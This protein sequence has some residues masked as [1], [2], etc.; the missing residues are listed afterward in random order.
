MTTRTRST[1]WGRRS[2]YSPKPIEK[3]AGFKINHAVAVKVY[4]RRRP[5][6]LCGYLD[7]SQGVYQ[8]GGDLTRTAYWTLKVI[9]LG[10]D[11]WSQVKDQV[12]WIEFVATDRGHAYRVSIH[13]AKRHGY[14]Y[15][16]PAGRRFGL[17]LGGF[18]VLDEAGNVVREPESRF[19]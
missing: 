12:D 6:K 16:S 11:E 1:D 7:P 14:E 13:A 18:R 15:D 19:A 2:Q 9:P 4:D 10:L 8:W 3:R 17:P 5:G